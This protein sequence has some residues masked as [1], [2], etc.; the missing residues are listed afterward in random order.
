MPAKRPGLD[1]KSISVYEV[2]LNTKT[3]KQVES[4]QPKIA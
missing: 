1:Y 2:A 4:Q 3:T